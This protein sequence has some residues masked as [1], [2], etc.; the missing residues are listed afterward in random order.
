WT[1]PVNSRAK[2][3][4]S[5]SSKKRKP[6]QSGSGSASPDVR[7]PRLQYQG[8]ALARLPRGI[9]AIRVLD[10]RLLVVAVVNDDQ[11][12]QRQRRASWK[13]VAAIGGRVAGE[14]AKPERIDREQPVATRVP[15]R[16]MAEVARAVEDRDTNRHPADRAVV[17]DPL[18]PFAP[19]LRFA[20]AA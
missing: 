9:R 19:D 4:S 2:P 3:N 8:D 7:F 11:V 5:A 14:R 16:R 17:V 15:V 13:R 10:A 18:R 12:A 6:P 20:P 1:S